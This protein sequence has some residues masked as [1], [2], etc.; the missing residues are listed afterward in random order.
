VAEVAGLYNWVAAGDVILV[1]AD[2]GIVRVNPT[3]RER[4]EARIS[5][6]G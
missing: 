5:R 1:D 4:D 2:H 3:R 6:G